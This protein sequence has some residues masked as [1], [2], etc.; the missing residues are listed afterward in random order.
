MNLLDDWDKVY[1]QYDGGLKT[2]ELIDFFEWL[3]R[4]YEPPKNKI[5]HDTRIPRWRQDH[6]VK[7]DVRN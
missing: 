2:S 4:N 3:K 6:Q 1:R 5:K 7:R